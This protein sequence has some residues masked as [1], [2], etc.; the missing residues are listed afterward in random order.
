[1]LPTEFC[2][3]LYLLTSRMLHDLTTLKERPADFRRTVKLS[4]FNPSRTKG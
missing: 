2:K 3:M 4:Y 1:M